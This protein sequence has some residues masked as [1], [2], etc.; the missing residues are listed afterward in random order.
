MTAD[1]PRRC[2]AGCAVVSRPASRLRDDEA[3]TD[4]PGLLLVERQPGDR[5]DRPWHEQE[6]VRVNGAEVPRRP[7]EG[8]CEAMPERLFVGERRM[9]QCAE[10]RTSWTTLRAESFAVGRPSVRLVSM[11]TSYSPG[12]KAS[13][14]SMAQAEAQSSC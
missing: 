10:M 13:R 3:M 14:C 4:P 12:A 8:R 5:P 1:R 11:S 9:A 2:A 7:R 6:T